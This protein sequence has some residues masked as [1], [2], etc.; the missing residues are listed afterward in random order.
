MPHERSGDTPLHLAVRSGATAS[1]F[2]GL[3]L[4]YGAQVC[5]VVS[6]HDIQHPT[7]QTLHR[8]EHSLPALLYSVQDLRY[9]VVYSLEFPLG[10]D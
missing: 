2:V 10:R 6:T 4:S 7:A 1:S 8:R 9:T 5:L 3:L